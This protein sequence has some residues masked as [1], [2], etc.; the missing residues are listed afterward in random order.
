MEIKRGE[1]YLADLGEGVG[2]EQKGERPVVIVQ[3]NKGNR[4]SPT[5]SVIP[6]TTKIHKSAGMPTHVLLGKISGLDELSA[7][8]A[9][10]VMTIDK[11]RLLKRIGELPEKVMKSGVD[12]ALKVQLD[13]RGGRRH[14]KT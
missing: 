6:I 14:G 12:A 9:E 13:L 5:V 10:Q 8:M 1:I 11:K 3:N 4:F 7:C 2:S